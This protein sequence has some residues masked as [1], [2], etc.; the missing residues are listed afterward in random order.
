MIVGKQYLLANCYHAWYDGRVVKLVIKLHGVSDEYLCEDEH[1]QTYLVQGKN[2]VDLKFQELLVKH[3]DYQLKNAAK[4]FNIPLN[5]V[6]LKVR[7][8][9]QAEY[10]KR[11]YNIIERNNIMQLIGRKL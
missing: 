6:T 10:E 1:C 9:V 2:L 3:G 7:E 4:A 8:E 11:L 5:K